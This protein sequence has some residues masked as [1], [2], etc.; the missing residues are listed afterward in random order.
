MASVHLP[1]RTALRGMVLLAIAT[2]AA[3]QQ[4][5]V[6]RRP[7]T[8]P[9]TAIFSVTVA[10]ASLHLRVGLRLGKA[11]PS[12]AYVSL[13]DSGGLPAG[14]TCGRSATTTGDDNSC[15]AG[16]VCINY[17]CSSPFNSDIYNCGKQGN[18][19]PTGTGAT[20]T[21]TNGACGLSCAAG[22]TKTA[23]G[24]ADLT[25]DES[26][27]GKVGTVC[28]STANGVAFCN[29]SVCTFQCNAGYSLSGSTCVSTTNDVNNCGSAGKKCPVPAGATA[30]TCVAST[31]GF[32]CPAGTTKTSTGCINTTSDP[33]NCGTAGQVCPTPAGATSAS[34]TAGK[35]SFVCGPGYVIS[36][37][38]CAL[39]TSSDPN[40][41][42]R[43]VFYRYTPD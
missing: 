13:T 34:C 11:C 36:G 3:Q 41:V 15:A 5:N 42:C 33:N 25:S 20:A 10:T 21:C 27:C 22:T 18:V 16:L 1:A 29:N 23:T 30:A 32:T 4:L 19:C 37:T 26:N 12:Q 8:L 6:S 2:M 39:D 14:S 28:P 9:V 35:C 31:C 40:N 7:A 24:C 43:S 17:T 38:T